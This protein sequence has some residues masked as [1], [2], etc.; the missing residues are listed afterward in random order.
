VRGESD[1]G[2]VGPANP[3]SNA[4]RRRADIPPRL[5]AVGRA[6]RA[7][8]R[9]RYSP[10]E[11]VLIRRHRNLLVRLL[12]LAFLCAQFGML[13]HASTHLQADPHG[14]PSA[15][16][17]GECLCS[18]PLQN[19]V[20]AGPGTVSAARMTPERAAGSAAFASIPSGAFTAFRSRAPPTLL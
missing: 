5:L 10:A 3:V 12:S 1:A 6:C 11:V 20:G 15:Q 4:T 19:I 7:A 8:A 16:L 13:A 9:R 17:C 18:A 2:V 14:A